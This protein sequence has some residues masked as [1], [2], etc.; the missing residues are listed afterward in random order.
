MLLKADPNIRT[1]FA[2]EVKLFAYGVVDSPVRGSTHGDFR[3]T[4]RNFQYEFNKATQFTRI[5][6]KI[7]NM[8]GF[9]FPEIS[10]GLTKLLV[11]QEKNNVLVEENKVL[12]EAIVQSKLDQK[13]SDN[14]KH[15]VWKKQK[16]QSTIL[17][18]VAIFI[19]GLAFADS[20]NIDVLG[21]AMGYINSI[22]GLL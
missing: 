19:A 14:E 20:R 2:D 8:A 15:A 5:R 12:L 13:I 17:S 7:K 11:E 16:D 18:L 9:K 3:K 1:T 22:R 21:I 10:E 4:N 6:E